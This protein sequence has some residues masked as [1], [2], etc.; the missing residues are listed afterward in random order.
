MITRKY[1][2]SAATLRTLEAL[3]YWSAEQAYQN[4]RDPSDA[5]ELERISKTI[6]SIFD[7]CDRRQISPL[8]VNQAL[9]FGSNWRQYMTNYFTLWVERR[10][11]I[12][13]VK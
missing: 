6:H 4:E 7:E 5:L 1:T 11:I 10:G 9:Y 3:A 13:T 2:V 12:L 8:L